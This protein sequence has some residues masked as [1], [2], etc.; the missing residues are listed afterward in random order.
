[1]HHRIVKLSVSILALLLSSCEDRPRR[2][3]APDVPM[4]AS[5]EKAEKAEKKASP[6]PNPFQAYVPTELGRHE[7]GCTHVAWS[8]DGNFLVSTGRDKLIKLW[9]QSGQLVRTLSGHTGPVAM[10]TFSPDGQLIASA[11]VDQTAR[12]WDTKTGRTLKVLRE[13][14]KKPTSPEAEVAFQALPDPQVNWVAFSPDGT[15]LAAACDDFAIRIFEVKT[16]KLE[17]RLSDDGCRQRIVEWRKDAPGWVSSAGCMD[18]G[19][20]YLRLWDEA[21]TQIASLGDDRHDA[22]F[23]AYDRQRRFLVAADGSALMTVYSAQGSLLR[24]VMVGAY[25]FAL[26]FGPDDQTLLVGGDGGSISVFAI[27]GF[28]RVGRLETGS[29]G[30]IDALA[31]HPSDGSLAVGTRDGRVLRFPTPVRLEAGR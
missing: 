1:M 20:A 14:R 6:P 4:D 19:V 15:R 22:H 7:K 12:L 30:A 8:P 17:R 29:P 2:E 21:G 3:E 11:S 13:P 9:G 28:R 31:L 18:D 10:A 27:E 24:Q 25:H 16:G 26:T 5:A 23:L